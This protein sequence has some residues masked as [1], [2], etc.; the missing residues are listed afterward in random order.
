MLTCYICYIDYILVIDAFSFLKTFLVMLTP[1]E[2]L[3]ALLRNYISIMK[4]LLLLLVIELNCWS[5]F[6]YSA[7]S[8]SINIF[9]SVLLILNVFFSLSFYLSGLFR[10]ALDLD[11]DLAFG[12]NISYFVIGWWLPFVYIFLLVEL[13]LNLPLTSCLLLLLTVLLALSYL[14]LELS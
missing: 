2:D 10:S 5:F 6:C 7:T 14:N 11:L 13:F 9:L 1:W 3:V 12:L 4:I 8:P